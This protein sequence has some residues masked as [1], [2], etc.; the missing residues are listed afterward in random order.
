[1]TKIMGK[2]SG[3]RSGFAVIWLRARY[4]VAAKMTVRAHAAKRAPDLASGTFADDQPRNLS[5]IE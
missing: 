1:M 4:R 3:I 5:S 2:G